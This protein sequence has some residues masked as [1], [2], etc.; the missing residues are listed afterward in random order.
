M[1]IVSP[2]LEPTWKDTELVLF[3]RE[4]PLN[5]VVEPRRSISDASCR[6][7]DWIADWLVAPSVPFL[8]W[9]ASSRTR[10]SMLCTVCR[11]PSAVWTSETPSWVLRWAWARPRIWPRIFGDR[12]AGGVVG[13]AVDP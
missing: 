1:A 13:G 9:T 5:F 11:A 12:E 7:S 10:C 2:S 3:S 6:T 4:M 8:Y